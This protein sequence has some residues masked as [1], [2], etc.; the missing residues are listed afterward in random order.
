MDKLAYFNISA[1]D[2]KYQGQGLAK[3]MRQR[4][5]EIAKEKGYT[6]CMSCATSFYNQNMLAN[7][8]GLETLLERKYADNYRSFSRMPKNVRAIH[9]SA[10]IMG[11][12]LWT[13]H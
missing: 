1:V 12:L 8:F 4:A 5:I 9:T 10:K 2:G 11:R 13:S 3:R 7:H 6:G